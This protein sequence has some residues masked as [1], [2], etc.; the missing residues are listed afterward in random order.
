MV[1][2]SPTLALGT[3][4]IKESTPLSRNARVRL[5]ILRPVRPRLSLEQCA[6]SR[7]PAQALGATIAAAPVSNLSIS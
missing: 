3:Q 2:G 4:Y 6:P 7:D 1:P 5:V